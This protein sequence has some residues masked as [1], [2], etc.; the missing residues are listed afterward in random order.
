MDL[1]N[2]N[3][4]ASDFVKACGAVIPSAPVYEISTKSG[5]GLAELA[6]GVKSAVESAAA[7]E[8]TYV[9]SNVFEQFL[10]SQDLH[11]LRST[12]KDQM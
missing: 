6:I 3:D 12:V 7:H 1:P 4:L 9:D 11:L 10:H 2:S 8:I 5:A